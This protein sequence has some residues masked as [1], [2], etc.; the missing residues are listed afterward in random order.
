[1]RRQRRNTIKSKNNLEK[2]IAEFVET[3][4]LCLLLAE[5]AIHETRSGQTAL[6]RV[7]GKL[8]FDWTD[9]ADRAHFAE[10]PLP[11]GYWAHDLIARYGKP[12]VIK[13]LADH[14]KAQGWLAS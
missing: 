12:A 1:M 11:D 13:A 7:F 2:T 14:A 9:L 6:K 5:M 4:S 8:K 10:P 3:Y